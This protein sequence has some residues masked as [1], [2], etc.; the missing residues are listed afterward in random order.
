MDVKSREEII[1]FAQKLKLLKAFGV[2]RN[3]GERKISKK[4]TKDARIFLFY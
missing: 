4:R 1:K 3:H 2:D